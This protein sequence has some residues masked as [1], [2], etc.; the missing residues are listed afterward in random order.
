VWP[1]RQLTGIKRDPTTAS[2]ATA[3]HS[4]LQIDGRW[5]PRVVVA[6]YTCPSILARRQPFRS[7]A[8]G[9]PVTNPVPKTDAVFLKH[10]VQL[11]T[12]LIWLAGGPVALRSYLYRRH[13]GEEN[14]AKARGTDLRLPPVG[15]VYAG[16]TG[17]AAIA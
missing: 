2:A 11:I 1:T 7:P 9:G 17:R 14:P 10:F 3:C 13:P 15:G 12:F 4:F 8:R 6:G 16:D 5:L